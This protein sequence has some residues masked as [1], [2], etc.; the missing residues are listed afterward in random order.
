[1]RI[2]CFFM[3]MVV[4]VPVPVATAMSILKMAAFDIFGNI[5]H[6]HP[7]RQCP[8]GTVFKI[9]PG[10]EKKRRFSGVANI[11]RTGG[12]IMRTA[13]FRKHRYHVCPVS[14]D[15]RC[16]KSDWRQGLLAAVFFKEFLQE[17]DVLIGHI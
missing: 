11:R 7:G 2:K 17:F 9:H 16:N 15:S 5:N 13:P 6:F 10:S 4:S 8:D 12:I 3:V 14:G 1:M